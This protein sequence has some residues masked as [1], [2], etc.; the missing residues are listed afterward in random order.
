MIEINFNR[1]FFLLFIVFSSK[2]I[3]IYNE[4]TI[5]LLCFITFIYSF[6]SQFSD[7]IKGMLD[8]RNLLIEKSL[9]NF[10]DLEKTFLTELYQEHKKRVKNQ[11]MLEWL[12]SKLI[13]FLG[14]TNDAREKNLK[15]NNYALFQQKLQ[16][17]ARSQ[18]IL[19]D[20]LQSTIALRFRKAI[21]EE[22]QNSA[23]SKL[24]SKI[25]KEA[26]IVALSFK[27]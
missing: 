1:F 5:V 19:P 2:Q 11:Q 25:T 10:L 22:Y 15:V 18:N 7:N 24:S 12:S 23:T 21:L 6:Y 17:S 27:K 14:E 3:L 4:E 9:Q 20:K 13:T 16:S 8:E 26:T